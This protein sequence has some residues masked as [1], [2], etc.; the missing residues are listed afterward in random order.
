M[1]KIFKHWFTHKPN[2][3]W[4]RSG[5]HYNVI[6]YVKY[7]KKYPHNSGQREIAMFRNLE[8]A[9]LFIKVKTNQKSIEVYE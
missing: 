4:I 1:K 9:K 5:Q 8:D 6:S 7:N 3:L 2:E